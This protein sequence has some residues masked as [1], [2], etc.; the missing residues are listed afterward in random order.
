[1]DIL[2]TERLENEDK[3]RRRCYKPLVLMALSSFQ[4]KSRMRN[5]EST[6]VELVLT[7]V[8]G[9]L[10]SCCTR[11]RAAVSNPMD[12]LRAPLAWNM[13][14]SI[15]HHGTVAAR[16]TAEEQ[17]RGKALHVFRSWC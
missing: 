13:A 14:V 4:L 11:R 12:F 8:V 9:Q 3:A 2:I 15:L 16:V 10:Q 17:T 1:M 6:L 5:E 7:V